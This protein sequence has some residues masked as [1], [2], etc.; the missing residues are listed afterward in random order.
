MKRSHITR[1]AIRLLFSALLPTFEYNTSRASNISTCLS[2]GRSVDVFCF[3]VFALRGGGGG[4]GAA[5]RLEYSG[6]LVGEGLFWGIVLGSIGGMGRGRLE[7]GQARNLEVKGG[8]GAK[9]GKRQ[10]FFP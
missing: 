10:R 8:D 7:G 1:I 9:V 4:R 5:N 2:V 6:C 3:F